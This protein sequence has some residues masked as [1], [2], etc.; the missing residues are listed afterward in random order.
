MELLFNFMLTTQ[1]DVPHRW[2]SPNGTVV[3]A[4]GA[5]DDTWSRDQFTL[6]DV[7][8]SLQGAVRRL[9]HL[10]DTALVPK[11]RGH[12]VSSIHKLG[13]TT[14]KKGFLQRPQMLLQEETV[15]FVTQYLATCTLDGKTHFDHL[16]QIPV[17]EAVLYTSVL[18][19]AENG[20]R[21]REQRYH[22]WR[23]TKRKKRLSG[24]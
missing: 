10:L 13:S 19:P 16:P 6:N 11:A 18:P 9:E 22:Q 14:F 23:Q 20:W 5:H 17:R 24:G 1:R 3:Y 8:F 2:T 21:A 4:T 12:L 15:G 7:I